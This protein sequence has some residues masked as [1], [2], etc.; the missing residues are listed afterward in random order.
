M[1]DEDIIHS[2]YK[3]FHVMPNDEMHYNNCDCWCKPTLEYSE[4][5]LYNEIWIHTDIYDRGE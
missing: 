3:T 4:D 1:N 2:D 5:G